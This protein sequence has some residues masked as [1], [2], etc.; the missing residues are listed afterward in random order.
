MTTPHRAPLSF[1][2]P[3]KQPREQ[4]VVDRE[5]ARI[6]ERDR[7]FRLRRFLDSIDRSVPKDLDVVVVAEYGSTKQTEQL[8]EW[9]QHHL[10]FEYHTTPTHRWWVSLFE[11][12][13]S[14]LTPERLGRSPTELV[15]SI[16]EWI[17]L[18]DEDPAP[19]IWFRSRDEVVETLL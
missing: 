12:C 19:F 7:D 15:T 16:N 14:A 8:R 17:E 5:R 11:W 4:G 13:C 9:F 6:V 3:S 18:F 1:A 2:T 10:R